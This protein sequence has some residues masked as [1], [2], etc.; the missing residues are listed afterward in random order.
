M[1]RVKSCGVL[2]FRRVPEL[3]FLLMKH[4]HRFDLPK[5]HIEA[6]ET[7]VECALREMWEETGVPIDRVTLDPEF[8]YEE[9]YYPIEPRFGTERVEKTLVIFVGW[10]H[11]FDQIQVSEHGGHEWR[12]WAPPHVIQKHTINPLLAAVES[13]FIRCPPIQ[14]P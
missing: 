8:R 4:T 9:M 11:Q 1:R 6:G 5:G 14:L 7:E 13:H 10:I 12:K 2:L 3:S